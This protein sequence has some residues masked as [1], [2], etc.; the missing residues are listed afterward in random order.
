MS[1]WQHTTTHPCTPPYRYN[2]LKK[3]KGTLWI[4]YTKMG[5]SPQE[6]G[7]SYY[8]K[9]VQLNEHRQ[10]VNQRQTNKMMMSL[11]TFEDMLY[12]L[13]D[14]NYLKFAGGLWHQTVG[15]AMGTNCA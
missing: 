12:K 5:H 15:I 14:N 1:L 8:N 2:T 3:N 7:S 6:R 9:K 4:R 13:V 10:A 11:E